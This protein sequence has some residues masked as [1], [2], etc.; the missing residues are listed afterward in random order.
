MQKFFQLRDV[1]DCQHV[2]RYYAEVK[3]IKIFQLLFQKWSTLKEIIYILG[4][5]Y[6]ATVSLQEKCLTLSD[7]YAIWLKMQ[8]H[9]EACKAHKKF[10]TNLEKHLFNGIETRKEDIF[11]NPLM[12]SALFLDPRFRN[13]IINDQGKLEKAKNSLKNIWRRLIVLRSNGNQV[14]SAENAN[15]SSDKSFEYDEDAELK[16]YLAA[17]NGN[18][19]NFTQTENRGNNEDIVYLLDTFTPEALPLEKSIL[20]YW[21]ENKNEQKE[22]YEL[23]LVVF[24]VPSTEVQIERDFSRLNFVFSDLRGALA[25]ERLEDI[26]IIHLNDELFYEVK[27]DELTELR[28][29]KRN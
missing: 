7:T 17:L 15:V 5:P 23:A 4:I 9:L 6:K 14:T 29:V 24:S 8:L 1:Y 21:E 27:N 18:E 16:K 22:L 20:K 11:N 26:M 13:Q 10:K 3:E 25:A 2:I 28:S 12:A 19:P